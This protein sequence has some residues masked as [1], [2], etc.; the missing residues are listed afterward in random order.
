MRRREQTG[1]T[2]IS[3]LLLLT[4]VWTSH[5]YHF[6]TNTL[7]WAG[8]G[9]DWGQRGGREGGVKGREKARGGRTVKRK[10]GRYEELREGG[11]QRMRGD[12]REK[13]RRGR[14]QCED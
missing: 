12:Y 3:S 6:N 5:E 7:L 9:K 11:R 13:E 1:R 14:R 2:R 10:Q 8:N 4:S